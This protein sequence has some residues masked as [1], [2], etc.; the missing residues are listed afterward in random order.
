MPSTRTHVTTLALQPLSFP[1]SFL[2]PQLPASPWLPLHRAVAT[3]TQHLPPSSSSWWPRLLPSLHPPCLQQPV[4]AQRHP[5]VPKYLLLC[6][7]ESIR[8]QGSQMVGALPAAGSSGHLSPLLWWA[9]GGMLAQQGMGC[10]G[11]AVLADALLHP[12]PAPPPA[13]SQVS[14]LHKLLCEFEDHFSH[15][16]LGLQKPVPKHLEL[17]LG[18]KK[19]PIHDGWGEKSLL[20]NPRLPRTCRRP[21]CLQ[22]LGADG[23][24]QELTFC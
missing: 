11:R 17:T 12:P 19:K 2:H 18:R 7:L 6:P 23:A 10:S 9:A 15:T 20:V 5:A 1:F 3:K 8:S 13:D 16:C 4:S 14:P 21:C 24:A 22:V